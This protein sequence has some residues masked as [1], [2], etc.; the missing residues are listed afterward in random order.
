[1]YRLT[2]EERAPSTH[3]IGGWVDP[4]ACLDEAKKRKFLTLPGLEP[5]PLGHVALRQSLYRLRY[6]GSLLFPVRDI[7]SEEITSH[8]TWFF[9]ICIVG[10]GVQLDPLDTAAT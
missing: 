4:S 7:K 8:C 6:P 5:R 3:W 1:M 2:L 10:G 9:L